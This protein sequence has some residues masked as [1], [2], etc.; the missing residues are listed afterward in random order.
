MQRVLLENYIL[1]QIHL[2]ERESYYNHDLLE[3]G[4][5]LDFFKKSFSKVKDI[6]IANPDTEQTFKDQIEK[7]KKRGNLKNAEKFDQMLDD[8]QTS[9][10]RNQN[11]AIIAFLCSFIYLKE[12]NKGK[13]TEQATETTIEQVDN[14]M[15]GEGNQFNIKGTSLEKSL[16]ERGLEKTTLSEEE[17]MKAMYSLTGTSPAD[18]ENK[19]TASKDESQDQLDEMFFNYMEGAFKDYKVSD[20][21]DM[22]QEDFDYIVNQYESFLNKN[23]F[24]FDEQEYNQA[25]S[26]AF[27][28]TSS[29]NY[30]TDSNQIKDSRERL[31]AVRG[32]LQTI[33]TVS[34][35]LPDPSELS[36]DVTQ[37]DLEQRVS[38]MVNGQ[39]EDVK[40]LRKDL[41]DKYNNPDNEEYYD[42]GNEDKL[43]MYD[44][45]ISEI[46]G[47]FESTFRFKLMKKRQ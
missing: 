41:E 3:E 43:A 38:D 22:S 44:N 23:T 31:E 21:N 19:D 42:E 16:K 4:K 20:F 13:T 7:S 28:L 33:E 47:R 10:Y 40:K 27:L 11:I 25:M 17:M 15:Q 30:D 35:N 37:E 39:I 12:T 32:A 8:L 24:K 45:M 2:I 34:N 26:L 18:F 46:E 5:I 6:F 29:D 1:E 9:R 14:S 36:P